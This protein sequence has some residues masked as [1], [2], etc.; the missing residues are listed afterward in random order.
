METPRVIPILQISGTDVVKTLKFKNPTYIGDP[1]NSVRI[2][3]EKEVDELF[4]IDIAATKNREGPNYGL[5]EDLASECFMPF[6]YGG[7][8]SSIEQAKQIFS[9]GVEKICVQHA[10]I[11][12]KQFVQ[13]LAD[14]FGS[15]SIVVSV[16]VKKDWF[17]RYR[18]YVPTRDK[19]L[20][21]SVNEWLLECASLGA[22]E[23]LLNSVDRDGTLRGP[24]LPLIKSATEIMPIPVTAVGGVSSL[25]DILA[26]I[27]S[28]ASA[29]A[30]GSFFVFYGPHRAVL[31][32]YPSRADLKGLFE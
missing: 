2:F 1:I 7:G 17:S 25:D 24:D 16:D 29:V 14:T 27:K 8:I 6:A 11:E 18:P 9:L 15:Q 28:G 26:A 20:P 22:G 12:D 4:V 19:A 5:I 32:T 3:N 10:A 21:F 13:K 30:A 23:I 31:I